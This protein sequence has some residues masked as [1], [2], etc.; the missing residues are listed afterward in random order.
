MN[1]GLFLFRAKPKKTA[2]TPSNLPEMPLDASP[3]EGSHLLKNKR[4]RELLGEE[5]AT[6]HQPLR[7][8]PSGASLQRSGSVLSFSQSCSGYSR[9]VSMASDDNSDTEN[10]PLSFTVN[11][12]NDDLP[13]KTPLQV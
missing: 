10:Q 11:D 1:F 3:E 5:G 12:S 8:S 7:S 2:G 4:L 6:H 9:S 13:S